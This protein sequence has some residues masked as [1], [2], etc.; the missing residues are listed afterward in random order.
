MR[1]TVLA[2]IVRAQPLLAEATNR[3]QIESD[4]RDAVLSPS[5]KLL[6]YTVRCGGEVIGVYAVSKRVN[7]D[8]YVSHFFVQD[9]VVL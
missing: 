9:Q 1:R 4:L 8:Y 5:S 2:D 3:F 6:S 7:L